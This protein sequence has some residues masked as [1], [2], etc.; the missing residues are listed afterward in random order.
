[1]A[2]CYAHKYLAQPSLEKPPPA[3]DGNKH[4]EPQQDN[5]HRVIDFETLGPKW[6]SSSNLTFTTQG[7][8]RKK[9]QETKHCKGHKN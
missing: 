7:N 4:R 9:K 2:F 1:M 5:I 6:M 8:L 3:A